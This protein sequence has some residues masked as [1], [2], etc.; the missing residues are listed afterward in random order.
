GALWERV[1]AR[2]GG[3]WD[4]PSWISGA[5]GDRACGRTPARTPASVVWRASTPGAVRRVPPSSLFMPSEERSQQ[6]RLQT[7]QEVGSL[8]LAEVKRPPRARALAE[9]DG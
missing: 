1:A 2:G 6:P 7:G 5:G 8:T 4:Q 3:A 9:V